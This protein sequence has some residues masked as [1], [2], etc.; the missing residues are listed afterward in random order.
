V[1]VHDDNGY[2]PAFAF[3]S[4]HFLDPAKA[5]LPLAEAISTVKH[6]LLWLIRKSACLQPVLGF[7]L[8]LRMNLPYRILGVRH[9][10]LQLFEFHRLVGLSSPLDEVITY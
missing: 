5:K 10:L 8:S 9:L 1:I 6:L 4:R 3:L 7:S 2:A